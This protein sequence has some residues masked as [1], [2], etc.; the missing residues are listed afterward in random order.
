LEDSERERE[1]RTKLNE[2]VEEWHTK[3]LRIAEL[4][5]TVRRLWPDWK[6]LD[7]VIRILLR[8]VP[9]FPELRLEELYRMDSDIQ[10]FRQRSLVR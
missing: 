1:L 2:V 6:Q 4:E 8:A 10:V 3:D 5:E 7:P 9:T